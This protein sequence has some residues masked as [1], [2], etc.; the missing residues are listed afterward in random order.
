MSA[1]SKNRDQALLELGKRLSYFD[2]SYY[3]I[4]EG[5]EPMDRDNPDYQCK[6]T[7]SLPFIELDGDRVWYLEAEG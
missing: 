2:D 4:T 5:Y 3:K 1:I 7:K 6:G